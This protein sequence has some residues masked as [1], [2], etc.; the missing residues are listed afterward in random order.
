M[1]QLCFTTL[2]RQNVHSSVAMARVGTAMWRDKERTTALH[3]LG[4]KERRQTLNG[5]TYQRETLAARPTWADDNSKR[6][7]R[8]YEG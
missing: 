6:A 5:T 7:G 8:G 2:A 3:V 4:D 1:I